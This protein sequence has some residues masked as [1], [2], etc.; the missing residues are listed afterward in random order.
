MNR[1]DDDELFSIIYRFEYFFLAELEDCLHIYGRNLTNNIA[2][3]PCIHWP[4]HIKK[5]TENRPL[6]P[7][8]ALAED[9]V[10][11]HGG[12]DGGVQRVER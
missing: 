7:P 2:L 9:L 3:R 1:P 12:G 10:D 4:S 5:V 8:G 11:E 6:S